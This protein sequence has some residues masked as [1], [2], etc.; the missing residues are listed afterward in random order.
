MAKQVIWTREKVIEEG[1]RYSYRNQFRRANQTAY[2]EAYKKGYLNE[3]FKD[4]PNLGYKSVG[5]LLANNKNKE[6][7]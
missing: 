2:L 6:C 5:L 7:I 3:I 1:R 4:K